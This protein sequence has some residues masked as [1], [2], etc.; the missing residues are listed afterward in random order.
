MS[1]KPKNGIRRMLSVKTNRNWLIDSFL[2]ISAVAVVASSI[3]YLY[4]P[5]GYQGGRNPYYNMVILFSRTGWEWIHT[6]F[7]LAMILIATIHLILH[8]N[9]FVVMAKKLWLQVAG[10]TKSF[11]A[12]GWLNLIT[13]FSIAFNFVLVSLSGIYFLFA[14]SGSSIDPMFLFSRTVWDMIHT[15]SGVIMI[16]AVVMHFSIHWRWIVNV[17]RRMF[18][19][20]AALVQQN[21]PAGSACPVQE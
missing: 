16:I 3:Y 13:D 2:F 7:G 11:N 8:W 15:W 4:I 12:M 19:P 1:T 18:T 17:S 21:Q 10:K 20:Q 14:P 5:S 9:W 6:W